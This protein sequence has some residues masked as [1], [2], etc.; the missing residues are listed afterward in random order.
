MTMR[1]T[2][3]TDHKYLGKEIDPSLNEITFEDG[4]IF[5]IETRVV[6]IGGVVLKNSNYIIVCQEIE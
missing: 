4:F 3:T 1:I 5:S 6:F 2:A